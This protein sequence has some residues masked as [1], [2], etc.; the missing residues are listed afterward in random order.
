MKLKEYLDTVAGTLEQ[1]IND[2]KKIN[3]SG[4]DKILV[5]LLNKL[6]DYKKEYSLKTGQALLSELLKILTDENFSK[7]RLKERKDNPRVGLSPKEKF[8]YDIHESFNINEIISLLLNISFDFEKEFIKEKNENLRLQTEVNQLNGQVKLLKEQLSNQ[9]QE[10]TQLNV[11]LQNQTLNTSVLNKSFGK[12]SIYAVENDNRL[13]ELIG[14]AHNQENNI[15]YTSEIAATISLL[16]QLTNNNK[17]SVNE[18]DLSAHFIYLIFTGQFKNLA[19]ELKTTKGKFSPDFQDA[20]NKILL[21]D[22]IKNNIH[23]NIDFE[24]KRQTDAI[25]EIYK[26]FYS[27]RNKTANTLPTELTDVK[28]N[29]KSIK[30][31]ISE[32]H[33]NISN[34]HNE[35]TKK[36]KFEPKN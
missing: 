1:K 27:S 33:S 11:T 14:K 2:A 30:Q 23:L 8:Y 10:I 15:K 32:F 20:I 16:K 35:I 22:S 21:N 25:N 18:T 9:Q 12:N 19:D 29:N 34:S 36:R 5:S 28:V 7:S 24:T 6:T 31:L 26:E 4:Y 17:I 3:P 13:R